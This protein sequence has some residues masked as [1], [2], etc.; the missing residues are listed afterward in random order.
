MNVIHAVPPLLCLRVSQ[1]QVFS[2]FDQIF[3]IFFLFDQHVD[4]NSVENV[5]DLRSLSYSEINNFDQKDLFSVH[6]P[7]IPLHQFA[8]NFVLAGWFN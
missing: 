6:A 2:C 3:G 1:I 5:T 4:G 7:S 8:V